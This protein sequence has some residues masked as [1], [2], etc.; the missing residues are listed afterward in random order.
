MAHGAQRR[1]RD[2]RRL[3]RPGYAGRDFGGDDRRHR[4]PGADPQR[5]KRPAGSVD[6]RPRPSARRRRAVP[7]EAA[8]E[9]GGDMNTLIFRTIAP[10]LVVVML[11]FSVFILLRGHNEPGGGF[12]GGLI[13]ASAIAIYGMAAGP[14]AVRRALKVASAGLRRLRRAA[15]RP[16]GPAVAGLRRAIPDRALDDLHHRRHRGGRCRRR[17]LRHRRLFRRVRHAC[18]PWRWRSRTRR[19]PDGI[20]RRRPHRASFSSPPSICCCRAR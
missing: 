11:V 5:P 12:I 14:A 10:L 3:P 20:C 13:A 1:Q 15:G 6:G 19:A 17:C 7:A 2:P 4:H 16:V 8:P 18:R 9:E